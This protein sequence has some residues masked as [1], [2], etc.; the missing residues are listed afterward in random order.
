MDLLKHLL[1][2]MMITA[3][4]WVVS[5]ALLM[6]VGYGHVKL[7]RTVVT[8]R[9]VLSRIPPGAVFHCRQGQVVMAWY[10][11][12]K[13]TDETL[14]FA[15][16]SSPTLLKWKSGRGKSK[17]A[18]GRRLAGEL[19]WRTALLTLVTVPLLLASVWLAFNESW[20]WIYATLFLVIHQVIVGMCGRIVF[21]RFWVVGSV[22]TYL[23]VDRIGVWH[24][25]PT[26]AASLLFGGLVFAMGLY[27]SAERM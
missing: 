24:P 12:A 8:L 19:V 25:S 18:L 16:F 2:A 21:F 10:N 9:R 27:V 23:F 4:L 20:L 14:Q 6:L 1:I 26:V 7:I 13:D 15:R 11:G 5:T 22:T 3:A 17:A